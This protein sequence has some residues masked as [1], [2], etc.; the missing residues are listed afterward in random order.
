[1]KR[2]SE[3][4]D[5]PKEG[6][7][8]GVINNY[9]KF[10]FFCFTAF[11]FLTSCI[12]DGSS[13]DGSGSVSSTG[14]TTAS[15]SDPTITIPTETT[16][17]ANGSGNSL[18]DDSS[19]DAVDSADDDYLENSTFSTPVTI[20]YSGTSAALSALPSGI[21]AVVDGANVTITSTIKN[22]YYTLSGTTTDGSLKI[23]SDKKFEL[24]FNGV[25]ITSTTGAAINIQSSKTTFAVLTSGTTNT[26]ADA[27]SYSNVPSAEDCKGTF[28]SEGQ[29]V[30]SG[31][32]KL[33]VQGNYK[34]A[35]CS[36]DYVRIRHGATV[37]VT[38]AVKDGIHVNDKFV[39]TGGLLNVTSAGDAVE[40]EEGTIEVNGGEIVIKS[41]G[42]GLKASYEKVDTNNDGVDDNGIT[43]YVKVTG[44]KITSTTTGEKG[45]GINSTGDVT[46]SGGTLA[47]QAGGN[48][49]KAIKSDANVS[50]TGGTLTLKTTGPAF[51]DTDDKDISSP[52]CINADGN[53]TFSGA[54][55]DA[56]STGAAGK[57]ISVDGTATFSG[58]TISIVTTG[59]KYTYGNDDSSPKGIKAEGNLAIDG[60]AIAVVT[61]GGEGSEGIE[62]KAILTINNGTIEV[63]SYDDCIN[64]AKSIVING[65]KT[66]CFSSNNDAI[67]SNGTMT[68]TG[69]VTLAVGTT[70]PEAGFDCDQNTFTITGGIII[71]TGGDSST[72]SSSTTQNTLLYGG[73]G[74]AGNCVNIT[75]SS[76]NSV[77]MFKIPKTYSSMVLLVSTPSFATSSTYNIY[78]GGS[79]SGGTSF[80]NY[81]T[82]ATYSGGSK[83]TSFTTSSTV[84]KVGTFTNGGGDNP[85]GGGQPGR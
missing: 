27:S 83:I 59:Q 43:P 49:A 26:L 4:A 82:D 8:L 33:S 24:I 48:G 70:T 5:G 67:D 72:P 78:G 74:G 79:I 10:L 37:F 50:I 71:G 2:K 9:F 7:P 66:Y 85:G 21:T 61:S 56:K 17:N 81:Y 51:Y 41:V 46:I 6:N 65:G 1:M 12:K 47:L 44:G 53:L 30:F 16:I 68:I 18:A 84:T 23:Y 28:F 15:A 32:G 13:S 31:T 63:Q 20:T 39:M 62:S 54:T 80:H 36:D 55:L 29:I 45:H 25:N 3:K 19:G 40:A 77:I 42:D 76:G 58:G 69:G 57:G 34:H 64:A 11:C 38:G 35:I 14:M 60:G 52:A 22:V 73:S 75:N